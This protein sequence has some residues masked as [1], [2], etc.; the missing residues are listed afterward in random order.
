MA[1]VSAE[2]SS[3]R[4][5]VGN[6][7]KQITLLKEQLEAL[8]NKQTPATSA[9]AQAER[10]LISLLRNRIEELERD[11]KKSEREDQNQNVLIRELQA[12]LSAQQSMFNKLMEQ[13]KSLVKPPQ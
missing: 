10:Q 6:R 8:V 12:K 11:K 1:A 4:Q 3:L 9:G 5:E 7:D 13:V 2:L